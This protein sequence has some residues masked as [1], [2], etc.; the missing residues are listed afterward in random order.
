MRLLTG[1]VAHISARIA[2]DLRDRETGLQKPHIPGLADLGS[3]IFLTNS[4]MVLR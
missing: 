2:E 1:G 4:S 3:R